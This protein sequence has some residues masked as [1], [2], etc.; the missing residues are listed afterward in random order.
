MLA[1]SKFSFFTEIAYWPD[2]FWALFPVLGPGL[3]VLQGVQRGVVG[4][5]WVRHRRFAEGLLEGGLLQL[6][7]EA[8]G[9]LTLCF[10][11]LGCLPPKKDALKCM[12]IRK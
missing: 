8:I 11:F 6:H 10:P 2:R 9:L 12:H 5:Q 4:A 1:R 7:D 3:E